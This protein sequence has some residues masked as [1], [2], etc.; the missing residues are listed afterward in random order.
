MVALRHLAFLAVSSVGLAK[1]QTVATPASPRAFIENLGQYDSRVAYSCDAGVCSIFATAEGFRIASITSAGRGVGIVFS[2]CEPSGASLRARERSRAP[3]SGSPLPGRHNFFRGAD[4]SHFVVGARGFDG[5]VYPDVR[6]GVDVVLHAKDGGPTFDFAVDEG[7]DV[8]NLPE[9]EIDGIDGLAVEHDGSA[10]IETAIGALR[11]TCPVSTAT[12]SDGRSRPLA[13]RFELSGSRRLRVVVD[14]QE[15]G[16]TVL[17]D[18]SLVFATYLGGNGP[19][20]GEGARAVITDATGAP[21]VTG[22]MQ[23]VDFPVTPGAFDVTPNGVQDVTVTKLTPDGSALVFSTLIGGTSYD[24]PSGIALGS[25]GSIFVTGDTQSPNFPV[26]P[27]AFD[28]S[29]AGNGS[30]DGFLV[31]LASNGS[32]L[33]WSTFFGGSANDVPNDLAVDAFGNA[34]VAGV[35]N[36]S[37]Y[38]TTAGALDTVNSGFNDGFVTKFAPGGNALIYSTLLGASGV[39]DSATGIAIGA[40]DEAFVTGFASAGFPFTHEAFD[41]SHNGSL[42]AFVVRLNAVGSGLVAGTFLGGQSDDQAHAIAI[43]A[44]G[45]V[46]ICGEAGIQFPTTPGAFNT[47]PPV[48]ARD[49]FIARFD[50]TLESLVYSTYFGST[51]E[52]DDPTDIAVDAGGGAIV[53]GTFLNGTTAFP[54][55]PGALETTFGYAFLSRLAPSGDSLTYST[56]LSNVSVLPYGLD[57]LADGSVVVVGITFPGFPVT[58]GAFDTTSSSNGDDLIAKFDLCPGSIGSYGAG[59]VGAGGFVPTLKITGCA[60]PGFDLD[61]ALTNALGHTSALLLVGLGAG[62]LPL[63]GSCAL[64]IGPLVPSFVV[65]ITLLGGGPGAGSIEFMTEVPQVPTPLEFRLQAVIADPNVAGGISASNP[66]KIHLDR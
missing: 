40:N 11:L 63:S 54:T 8:S 29:Y 6:P 12:R 21:I 36:S 18:P 39:L 65:P 51:N 17:V 48:N 38:P 64:A 31:R 28:T 4:P 57:S 52:D 60:S 33:V 16:E 9:I 41:P 49:A 50:P 25:D 5:V 26:T 61:V 55:T 53:T 45:A 37:N 58:Q 22:W 15:S 2:F 23:V 10:R 46:T 19:S 14:S 27:G 43:G 59:C 47:T 20:S 24:E 34:F 35:T 1:G 42:D 3:R 13:S 66:W 30:P 62:S 32:S 44:D 7:A 56:F